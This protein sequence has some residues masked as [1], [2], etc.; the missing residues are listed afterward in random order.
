VKKTSLN[1]LKIA[2]VHDWL[3]GM[4]GGEKVLEELIKIFPQ[5]DIFTL[6]YKKQNMSPL[7]NSC[8]VYTSFIQK[9]PF[10]SQKHQYYLPL[11][12]IAIEKMKLQNYDLIISTSHCVAKGIVTN[13][14]IPHICYCHTPM[15]YAWDMHDHYFKRNLFY[16]AIFNY[17]RI[18][19]VISANRVDA[20]IANSGYVSHRIA[21][22]YRREAA[23]V[24]PPVNTTKFQPRKKVPKSVSKYY[25]LVSALT[26]YKNIETAIKAF[27][28]NQYPLK[29][30]GTGSEMARLKKMAQK[31]ISFLGKVTDQMLVPLYQNC[32]AFIFPQE[33]DFGITALE[34]QACGKGVIAYGRG[35]ALESVQKDKTGVFFEKNCAEALNEALLRFHRLKINP[36]TCRNNALNFSQKKF[37]QKIIN[38]INKIMSEK[39]VKKV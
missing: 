23:V 27:N 28:I 19:D 9:L 16:T 6:V 15:R 1:K 35:G 10:A 13:S 24:H 18:W 31:N 30:V 7:I 33:E 32:T 3:T 5:A 39:N 2:L 20:F 37:Q 29:I 21:K 36:T 8:P 25:L 17:L 11:F 34:A 26:P 14:Q 38:Y 12:P 4:R 22:I